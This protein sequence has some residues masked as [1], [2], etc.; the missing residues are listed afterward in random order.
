VLAAP[1]P[2]GEAATPEHRGVRRAAAAT[3]RSPARW[4][5]QRGGGR[6]VA[7]DVEVLGAGIIA[8]GLELCSG[9]AR[10]IPGRAPHDL[11]TDD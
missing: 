1:Q 11:A 10:G 9:E 7:L 5:R 2:A 4:L 8:A 6:E 3:E